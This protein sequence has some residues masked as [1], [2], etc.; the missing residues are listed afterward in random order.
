MPWNSTELTITVR[1]WILQKA[2]YEVE[3]GIDL[4]AVSKT[5]ELRTVVW[6]NFYLDVNDGLGIDLIKTSFM[7]NLWKDVTDNLMHRPSPGILEISIL[8]WYNKRV[9]DEA[10]ETKQSV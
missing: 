4:N 10:L 8:T 3:V 2:I 1:L 7:M 6:S 9:G 5:F